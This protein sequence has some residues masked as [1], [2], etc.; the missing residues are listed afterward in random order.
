MEGKPCGGMLRKS[1]PLPVEPAGFRKEPLRRRLT[2][3]W[4]AASLVLSLLV[5]GMAWWHP[6][7]RLDLLVYDSF[8]RVTESPRGHRVAIVMID[9]ASLQTVGSWPWPREQQARLVQEIARSQPAS[10]SINLLLHDTGNDAGTRKLGAAVAEAGVPVFVAVGGQPNLAGVPASGHHV[11]LPPAFVAVAAA[12]LGHTA[13]SV[14]PDGLVR[15]IPRRITT[16][17]GDWASLAQ[18]ASGARY[19]EQQAPQLAALRAQDR[20]SAT[21][22]IPYS[23]REDFPILSASAVLANTADEQ[24]LTG[25]HVI[26]G[27]SATGVQSVFA[28]PLAGAKG[29]QSGTLIQAH[30]MSAMLEGQFLT[31][32]SWYAE[33]VSA[34]FA[35]WT[36]LLL[37]RRSRP[38]K[39]IAW[40]A[41]LVLCY[42]AFAWL[43]FSRGG[44][45]LPPATGLVGML[46]VPPLWFW[47]RLEAVMGFMTG[48]LAKFERETGH[49][50]R[51]DWGDGDSLFDQARLLALATDEARAAYRFI[52]DIVQQLPEA[53]LVLDAAG[54]LQL[55][56]GAATALLLQL[57]RERPGEWDLAR[58]L[59]HLRLEPATG[60]EHYRNAETASVEIR[61]RDGMASYELR[62]APVFDQEKGFSSWV[63]QLVDMSIVRAA[64]REREEFLQL[65]THDMRSPLASILA[66]VNSAAGPVADHRL[67]AGRDVAQYARR[68]LDL[69]DGFVM[70][71]R[72]RGGD[73]L[74]EPLSL[75]LVAEDAIHEV[76]P[77]ANL[78]SVGIELQGEENPWLVEGDYDLL[79]RTLVNLL[80]N[81]LNHSPP[82]SRIICSLA[83]RADREGRHVLV[84]LQDEGSGIPEHEIGRIFNRFAQVRSPRSS[85]GAGLGL[86]FVREVVTSHGGTVDC[87]SRP[88]E[89]TTFRLG[90]LAAEDSDDFAEP[91]A[92]PGDRPG[93]LPEKHHG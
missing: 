7:T 18:E 53:A 8:T 58:L 86:Q 37:V 69:A 34:L 21:I 36:T 38:A 4:M 6:L 87:D 39:A 55:A 89:G 93:S 74:R 5:A 20:E 88:G 72:V 73:G 63:V 51:T 19:P 59:S 45:W 26:L 33:L 29:Y 75:R 67:S 46:M 10:I 71:S 84:T 76:R 30:L 56:N 27:V 82:G 79:L 3:E 40:C 65:L 64:M 48:E 78:R 85:R 12:G 66:I 41:V 16:Q 23:A 32:A 42:L 9:D 61:S 17:E 22:L 92:D 60:G 28:T 77:Q 90:F 44:L 35:V 31:D 2:H 43:L 81:A 24:I 50:A 25:R 57:D 15:R 52:N 13:L 49:G 70:L 47:R 68:A 91:D 1:L 11:V 62:L 83:N 80:V 14:D 54:R